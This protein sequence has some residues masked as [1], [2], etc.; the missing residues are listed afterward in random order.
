MTI[1][2]CYFYQQ[3]F[4]LINRGKFKKM[5]T[6]TSDMK[7]QFTTNHINQIVQ[8]ITKNAEEILLA[9]AP[10]ERVIFVNQFGQLVEQIQSNEIDWFNVITHLHQVIAIIPK[11][12]TSDGEYHLSQLESLKNQLAHHKKVDSDREQQLQLQSTLK[13]GYKMFTLVLKKWRWFGAFKDDPTL[14]IIYD[15]IEQ[16]RNLHWIGG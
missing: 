1:G 13:Q 15:N 4:D 6:N 7:N 2:L 3:Y 11:T 5:N 16:Q 8:T 10:P 12:A 9:L 14:D